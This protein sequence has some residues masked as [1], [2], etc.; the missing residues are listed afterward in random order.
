MN[1]IKN[2]ILP[3]EHSGDI[4]WEQMYDIFRLIGAKLR[5]KYIPVSAFFTKKL[6]ILRIFPLIFI[7]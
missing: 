4:L 2:W 1:K 6:K 5:E 3:T 7:V